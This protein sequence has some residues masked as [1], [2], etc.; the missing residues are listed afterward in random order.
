MG[1][2]SIYI[3]IF[4]LTCAVAIVSMFAIVFKIIRRGGFKAAL[5]G[6]PIETTLGE[7]QGA[8]TFGLKVLSKSTGLIALPPTPPLVLRSQGKLTVPCA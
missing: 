6:A 4:V 1:A 7:I 8:I 5:F 3:A 2:D